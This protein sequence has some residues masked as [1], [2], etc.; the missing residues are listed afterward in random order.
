LLLTTSLVGV[1]HELAVAVAVAGD[2]A[3]E[4]GARQDAGLLRGHVDVKGGVILSHA[5]PHEANFALFDAVKLAGSA[6]GVVAGVI[7]R[8]PLAARG[9]LGVAIKV[10]DDDVGR[11]GLGVVDWE[12]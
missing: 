12:A 11:A 3:A 6:A 5:G 8:A 4:S 9:G 2:E 7:K 1:G 10:D